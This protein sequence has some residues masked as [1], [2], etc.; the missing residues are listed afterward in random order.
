MSEQ[1]QKSEEDA[2]KV[3]R[4]EVECEKLRNDLA[5]AGQR[6]E[7]IMGSMVNK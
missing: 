4:Y 1:Y 7:D 6:I 3:T 2:M 5:A